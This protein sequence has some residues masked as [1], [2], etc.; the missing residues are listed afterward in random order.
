MVRNDLLMKEYSFVWR[1]WWSLLAILAFPVLDGADDRPVFTSGITLVH[2][3]AQ[4][5]D[6]GGNPVS[7]LS[8]LDFRVFDEKGERPVVA[9]AAE[10]EPLDIVLLLDVSGSMNLASEPIA[11]AGG[12]A[13]SRLRKGDRVAA[14]VF[15]SETKLLAPFTDRF[16]SIE[17]TL[18]QMQTAKFRGSTY[19]YDGIYEAATLFRGV[20]S[21]GRRRAVVIVTDNMTGRGKHSLE[22]A[23]ENLWESDATLNGLITGRRARFAPPLPPRMRGGI[24]RLVARTGGEMLA[25]SDVDSAFPEILN[26]IRKRYSVYYRLPESEPGSLRSVRVELSADA[27]RRFPSARV[28]ARAMAPEKG[29]IPRP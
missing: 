12:R 15:S 19:C 8:K 3:E 16:D 29:L 4:V 26:R 25:V 23:M 9:F 10:P 28:L 13:L 11:I 7:G 27:N 14:M 17:E 6:T 1:R 18:R 24:Q 21:Q 5:R 2:V 20:D 22:S